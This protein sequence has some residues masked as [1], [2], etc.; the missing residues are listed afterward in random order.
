MAK[1]LKGSMKARGRKPKLGSGKRF[2]NLK[3]NLMSKGKSP[4]D[5]QRI[6]ASIRWKKY[7][8]RKFRHK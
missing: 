6:A 2:A 4:Q 3:A 7:P 1:R 5:A 8:N